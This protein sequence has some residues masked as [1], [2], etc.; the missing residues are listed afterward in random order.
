[1][2]PCKVMARCFRMYSCRSLWK[3]SQAYTLI[4]NTGKVK[5][6]FCTK[7]L[8]GQTLPRSFRLH[9]P[10]LPF[11]RWFRMSDN[12][13]VTF[14]ALLR[15]AGRGNCSAIPCPVAFPPAADPRY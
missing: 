10:P 11:L 4:V 3:H 9:F 15:A 7:T 6:V 12:C 8:D 13:W 5:S 14:P 2:E 1:M